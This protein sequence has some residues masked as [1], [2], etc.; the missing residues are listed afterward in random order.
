MHAP[1]FANSPAAL[2]A[3]AEGRVPAALEAEV[4]RI[5]A[6]SPLYGERFPLHAEPLAWACFREIPVLSKQEI[7]RRGHQAFFRDYAEIERGLQ[8]LTGAGFLAALA[9]GA[10]DC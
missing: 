9:F 6:R 7:V 3:A 1:Q 8:Q 2:G 10:C 5:Y 4:R